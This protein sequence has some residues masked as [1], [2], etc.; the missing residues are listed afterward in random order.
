MRIISSTE[1]SD[2]YELLGL[3][4]GA[5]FFFW[6]KLEPTYPLDNGVIF[7]FFVFSFLWSM[8]LLVIQNTST[9]IFRK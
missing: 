6:I 8:V 5:L 2:L 3:E 4:C 9:T 1:S 7:S